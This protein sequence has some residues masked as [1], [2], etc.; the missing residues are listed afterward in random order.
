MTATTEVVIAM[1]DLRK[2]LKERMLAMLDAINNQKGME[3][4]T[5]EESWNTHFNAFQMENQAIVGT[6][7]TENQ[8]IVG[9]IHTE[10]KEMMNQLLGM[11]QQMVS[12]W[13][14]QSQ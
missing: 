8:E 7:H 11:M 14:S 2:E 6:M 3:K 9:A 1:R 10:N 5:I 13:P 12:P 4:N